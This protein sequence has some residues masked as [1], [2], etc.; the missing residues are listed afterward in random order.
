MDTR[1]ADAVNMLRDQKGAD[2][3]RIHGRRQQ[4]ANEFTREM[5]RCLLD[6]AEE[7]RGG[8]H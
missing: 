7:A 8:G 2:P 1:W 3:R 6:A 5:K 4:Q